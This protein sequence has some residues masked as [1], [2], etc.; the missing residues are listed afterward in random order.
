M[1]ALPPS[2]V[3][4]PAEPEAAGPG[5]AAEL[6]PAEAG[7]RGAAVI[8]TGA[9]SGIG[10]ATARQ[11]GAAGACVLLAGRRAGPLEDT[12]AAVRA[13]G[14]RAACLP[15]DLADPASP[16]RVAGACLEHFGR[17]D[18][19]VNNAATIAHRPLADWGPGGFD[20]HVAVNIRA[21]FFLIQAALPALRVS[22]L[23][24][25]VNISSSSGTL[26]RVGQS[27]YGMTKSALDYLTKSLAGELAP[28]GVRV[29]TIAPGPSTPRSMPPGPMTW[30]RRTGG[31]AR[32]CR[33][34]GSALPP[35]WP[36]GSCCCWARRP[37]LSPVPSSR[38]MAARSSTVSKREAPAA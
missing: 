11:L 3:P 34:A 9:G 18:G 28:D 22:P 23:R 20:E 2:A 1:T 21:P 13:A 15:A 37:L 10:A 24:S 4:G 26:H 33:S 31:W 38:W 5:P 7:L 16:A 32:R 36:G 19:L 35:R 29:N 6:G 27:V 25:V 30:K 14:G 12:A 17:I 8:V